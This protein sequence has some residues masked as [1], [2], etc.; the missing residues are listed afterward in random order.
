VRPE[1]PAEVALRRLSSGE[2]HQ[3]ARVF[4]EAVNGANWRLPTASLPGEQVWKPIG[5][6][7]G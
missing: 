3:P 6:C 1:L 5:Q 7:S 4:V 2:D